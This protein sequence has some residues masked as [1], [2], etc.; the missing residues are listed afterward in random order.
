KSGE[1]P[2][3]PPKLHHNRD[4]RDKDVG[5]APGA[6]QPNPAEDA[7]PAGWPLPPTPDVPGYDRS[8]RNK[9]DHE[10]WRARKMPG[11]RKGR[12]QRIGSAGQPLGVNWLLANC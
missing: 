9:V 1:Q 12:V 3:A 11:E 10:H 4:S 2:L 8:Q 7:M 6:F 5:L